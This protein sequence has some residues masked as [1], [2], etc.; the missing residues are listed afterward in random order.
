[1]RCRFCK[2]GIQ[3]G[4]QQRKMI[5]IWA[6]PDGSEVW[7]VPSERRPAP[8]P[9]RTLAGTAHYKCGKVVE[10]AAKRVPLLGDSPTIETVGELTPNASDVEAGREIH[11]TAELEGWSPARKR[12]YQILQDRA[13]D[14]GHQEP[15]E[16]DWRDQTVMDV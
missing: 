13:A 12:Q 11:T 6:L 10:K 9:P 5:T 4:P 8:D 16:S 1:M 15:T 7:E 2:D 14:P 3:A